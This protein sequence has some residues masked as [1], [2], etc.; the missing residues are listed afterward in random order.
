MEAIDF[1]NAEVVII[2]ANLATV[3][4]LKLMKELYL[5]N[6]M[7]TRPDQKPIKFLLLPKDISIEEIS[8]DQLKK[9][10]LMKI[11]EGGKQ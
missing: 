1:N 9:I 7:R 6:E 2:K 10:G 3:E 4:R 5:F 11:P 8:E